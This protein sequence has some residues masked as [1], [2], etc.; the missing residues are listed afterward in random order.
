M[1][2]PGVESRDQN[3]GSVRSGPSSAAGRMLGAIGSAARGADGSFLE[4]DA[5][6]KA[7]VTELRLANEPPEQVL[8]QIKQILAD[9]GLK[10]THG[11]PD[12]TNMVGRHIVLYRSV[13]ESSIRHYFATSDGPEPTGA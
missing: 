1:E 3:D 12:P 6:A 7:L 2:K 8:L 11:P 5:A 9:A 13:I 10:P 4:V